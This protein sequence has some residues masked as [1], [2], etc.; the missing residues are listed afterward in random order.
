MYCTV[1][2][3]AAAKGDS[4]LQ[5]LCQCFFLKEKMGVVN[6]LSLL[7][8]ETEIFTWDCFQTYDQ[9]DAGCIIY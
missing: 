2:R 3:N 4:P 7:K 8:G 5:K 9:N 6:H 1:H